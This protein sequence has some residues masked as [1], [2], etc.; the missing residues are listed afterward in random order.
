[1]TAI[2]LMLAAALG[3]AA[4]DTERATAI[5][6]AEVALSQ[7][8]GVEPGTLVVQDVSAVEWADSSLGCPEKGIRYL[9]VLTAGHRVV[10]EYTGRAYVMHVG[11]GRAVRCERGNA[12]LEREKRQGAAVVVR[13]LGEA[14]RDLAGR[15]GVPEVE[16]KPSALRRTT[17]PDASL[18]CSRP[19]EMYAQVATEGF[20]IE[21]QVAETRYSYHTDQQ[22]VVFCPEK[23]PP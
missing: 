17:W 3:G 2:V 8:L 1:M 12:K 13:L 18:G 5:R 6:L 22:R 14:R 19:G 21:L 11:A 9:P 20:V 16:V 7:E 4:D 23:S 10:L 15:I